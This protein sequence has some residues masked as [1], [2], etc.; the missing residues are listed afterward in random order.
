MARINN[1]VFAGI[2]GFILV[3]S[4]LPSASAALSSVGVAV[5][6][7]QP[8]GD[9]SQVLNRPIGFEAEASLD[10]PAFMPKDVDFFL[11]LSYQPYTI[12]NL[13]STS[14]NF[15]GFYGGLQLWG[16]PS[17]FKIRPFFAAELGGVYDALSFAGV[18]SATSNSNLA[19]ALQA[20]PGLD[21]PIYSHVGGYIEL[22]ITAVFQKTTL[23]IWNATFGLRWRL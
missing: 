6:A 12:K 4:S 18:S 21:I 23:A 22:P 8:M 19:I 1:R 2:V 15:F 16:E 13:A 17:A 11:S 9:A 10:T 20:V 14:I 7:P 3:A 5:S